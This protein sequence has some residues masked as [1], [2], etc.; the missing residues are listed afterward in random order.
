MPVECRPYTVYQMIEDRGGGEVAKPT[1]DS[2]GGRDGHLRT[3][4][5]E[6]HR[7]PGEKIHQ[8]SNKIKG[9]REMRGIISFIPCT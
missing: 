3:Q 4:K 6:V 9:S 7:T 1:T 8:F 2:Q 5:G